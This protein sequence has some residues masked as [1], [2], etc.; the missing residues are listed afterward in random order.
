MV[1][2]IVIV[3][4][5]LDGFKYSKWLNSSIWPI[6]WIPSCTTTPGQSEPAS[7]GKE[8]VLHIPIFTNPSAQVGYDTRS[9]FKRSLTGLNSEFSWQVLPLQVRVDQGV[10]AI[11]GYST[12]PKTLLWVPHHQMQFRVRSRILVGV[13]EFYPSAELHS[14]YSNVPA[15]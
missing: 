8:E 13:G 3:C 4:K 12:S 14:V 6:D 5:H 1:S 2:S 15:D 10:V 9:I 7:K 11:N